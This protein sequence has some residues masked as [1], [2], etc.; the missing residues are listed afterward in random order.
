MQRGREKEEFEREKQ[1]KYFELAR[2][3]SRLEREKFEL[4]REVKRN[5]FRKES[6]SKMVT[7]YSL[8]ILGLALAAAFVTLLVFFKDEVMRQFFQGTCTTIIGALIGYGLRW[9]QQKQ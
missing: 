5:E 7:G 1:H 6:F 2:E 9:Q 8:V 4:E 3:T